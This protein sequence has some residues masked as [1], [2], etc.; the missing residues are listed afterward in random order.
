M[1][2]NGKCR[3]FVFF[4]SW[5]KLRGVFFAKRRSCLYF[6]FTWICTSRCFVKWD[7]WCRKKSCVSKLEVSYNSVINACAQT[8][9]VERAEMWLETSADIGN[10][11]RRNEQRIC[12]N[13]I[14]GSAVC[15]KQ[16]CKPM[17]CGKW[18]L[19][20]LHIKQKWCWFFSNFLECW[21]DISDET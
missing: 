15:W 20:T 10:V 16:V 4:F 19:Q 9:Y 6:V 13:L 11:H 8:G 5:K 21:L 17:R 3:C 18:P 1:G 12:G 14:W 7:L 2:E